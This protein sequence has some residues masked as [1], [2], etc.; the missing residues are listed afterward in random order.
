MGTNFIER[1]D[2]VRRVTLRRQSLMILF[3]LTFSERFRREFASLSRLEKENSDLT[4]VEIDD[5]LGFVSD[6]A[7]EVAP[8][9]AMPRR[10]GFNSHAGHICCGR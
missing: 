10:V 7:A 3:S 8:N 6:V 1:K 2:S 4:Q 9:D 5:M